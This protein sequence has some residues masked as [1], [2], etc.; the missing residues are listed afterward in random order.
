MVTVSIMV[1]AYALAAAQS[2]AVAMMGRAFFF[3]G[4]TEVKRTRTM[5]TGGR[6]MSVR[7]PGGMYYC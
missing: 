1:F 7:F 6:S 4:D 3:I 2:S 5:G